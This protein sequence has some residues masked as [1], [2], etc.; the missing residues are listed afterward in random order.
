MVQQQ[1]QDNMKICAL[2]GLFFTIYVV[3]DSGVDLWLEKHKSRQITVDVVKKIGNEFIVE[4]K[5]NNKSH[6][7]TV[8]T[9]NPLKIGSKVEMWITDNDPTTLQTNKPS[10]T[11]IV[12]FY[13]GILVVNIFILLL[14]TYFWMYKPKIACYFFG[15]SMILSLISL[16]RK[17]FI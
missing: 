11:L 14:Y 1:L 5:M 13:T 4:L 3:A 16:I 8:Q 17:L 7:I 12:S 9:Q 6:Q 2:I 15:I 10:N